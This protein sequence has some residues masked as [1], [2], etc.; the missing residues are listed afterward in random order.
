M[1]SVFHEARFNFWERQKIKILT[2]STA[3]FS[4]DTDSKGKLLQAPSKVYTYVTI[5]AFLPVKEKLQTSLAP[6]RLS[7]GHWVTGNSCCELH[8]IILTNISKYLH[9]VL[10]YD[11]TRKRQEYNSSRDTTRDTN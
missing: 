9:S 11:L 6:V 7:S 10:I 5:P 2:L 8:A 1:I 3:H 4:Y